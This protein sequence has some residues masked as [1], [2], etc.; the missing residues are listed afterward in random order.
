MRKALLIVAM[1][2]SV[3]PVM[4][5]TTITAVNEGVTR[6]PD[7]NEFA[8]IAICYSGVAG[9]D[10]NVRAFALD[11]NVDSDGN[12]P[13]FQRIRDFNTGE[14]NGAL[15]GGK[16][17][18]GIFPSRFR[19]FIY[20][21]S[22][23]WVDTNYNP[24]TAWNEPDTISPR[25]GIGFPKMTV[26][27]GTL[28]NGEA[29]RPALSGTLFRFDVNSHG[30]LGT[31]NL[32]IAANALRG[33]VVNDAGTA[34][35]PTFT[36]TSMTFTPSCTT[37]LNE[38]GVAKG[39]AETAWTGQGFSLNGTAVV[40]CTNVGLIRT[41]DTG[42]VT[43]PY[44]INYTYGIAATMPNIVGMN[45]TDANTALAT[46]GIA[47]PYGITYEPNGLKTA[48]T[49]DRST[50][51][52]GGA[53]CSANYVVDTNCLYT[54]RQFIDGNMTT[55]T[56]TA[57]QVTRWNNIGKPNCWCCLSHKRGNGIYT[58]TSATVTNALDLAAIKNVANWN[59]VTTAANACLDFDMS[60]SIG[61]TDL[62]KV[63]NAANWNKV[64][65]K[66]PPCQ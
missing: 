31:F 42:C 54:G 39:T 59:K 16:S 2:L 38:V 50:P 53:T 13:N 3:V 1:L 45:M 51:V 19:D 33:G 30:N 58:G 27:M 49:V 32:T 57:A 36:G 26:E 20:A 12:R 5:A 52:S 66:A 37:I 64:T 43:L 25:T 24:T 40:D 23:N 55:V 48:L 60:G 63:K 6:T 9:T 29:N 14:A 34:I 46:A 28:Y 56:I 21:A 11:I 44:T 47:A 10:A 15:V 41:Q 62:A 18:Y 65:G 61:A 7:G 35:T 22:P 17:G 4:A 8:T